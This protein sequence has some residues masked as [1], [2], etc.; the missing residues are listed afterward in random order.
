M[1]SLCV[2]GP[3]GASDVEAERSRRRGSSG[4]GSAPASLAAKLQFCCT[5]ACAWRRLC[6]RSIPPLAVLFCP[7][8]RR[9]SAGLAF[10]ARL[11]RSR[12]DSGRHMDSGRHTTA[13]EVGAAG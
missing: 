9:A 13:D 7:R 10:R 8:M 3:V 6:L 2:K 5:S 11:P 12:G 4:V 1:S